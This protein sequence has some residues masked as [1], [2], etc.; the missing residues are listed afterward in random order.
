ML[1]KEVVEPILKSLM[2][3]HDEVKWNKEGWFTNFCEVTFRTSETNSVLT[4]CFNNAGFMVP[5]MT[6][7]PSLKE[8]A[9]YH[10]AFSRATAVIAAL[11]LALWE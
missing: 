3:I 5:C 8:L 10:A 9:L 6:S 1:T 2:T 7:G 4:F 11:Q